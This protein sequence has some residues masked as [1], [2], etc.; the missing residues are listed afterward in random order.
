M[1]KFT[2]DTSLQAKREWTVE[3]WVCNFL[4][5]ES[6]N[7]GLLEGFKLRRRYWRGPYV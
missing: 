6:R 5:S 7:S 4:N 1:G 3:E 2:I